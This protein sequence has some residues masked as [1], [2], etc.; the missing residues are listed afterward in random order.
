MARAGWDDDGSVALDFRPGTVD[1]N[2]ATS[3]L[4]AKELSS[5]FMSLFADFLS[6][7]ERH[8]HELHLVRSVENTAK[9]RILL[10]HLFNVADEAF[11]GD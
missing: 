2:F 7:P 1:P 8:Q 11:H 9:I 10:G 5:V 6:G 4:H 3:F